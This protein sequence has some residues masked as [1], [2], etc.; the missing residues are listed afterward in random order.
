MFKLLLVC[1]GGSATDKEQY[2]FYMNV[3]V[4]G[5]SQTSEKVVIE[6]ITHIK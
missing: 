3:T 1:K 6:Y 4:V 5:R 2:V